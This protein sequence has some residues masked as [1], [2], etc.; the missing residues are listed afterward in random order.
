MAFIQSAKP[1]GGVECASERAGQV[2]AL[3]RD[4]T[5][6]AHVTTVGET[7]PRLLTKTRGANDKTR[8]RRAG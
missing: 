2:L 8:V 1:R 7:S 3:G 6:Q 5:D 4:R